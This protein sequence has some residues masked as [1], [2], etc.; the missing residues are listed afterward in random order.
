MFSILKNVYDN[1]FIIS[2]EALL[3]FSVYNTENNS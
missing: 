1:A 3:G 2:V